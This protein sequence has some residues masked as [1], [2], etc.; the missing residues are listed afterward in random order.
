MKRYLF[1]LIPILLIPLNV[2]ANGTYSENI[3]L[4]IDLKKANLFDRTIDILKELLLN[5]SDLSSE[6]KLKAKTLLAEAQ[7]Q[8]GDYESVLKTT[9]SQEDMENFVFLRAVAFNQLEHYEKTIEIF[10]TYPKAI[11]HDEMIYEV[12]F[13]Y[14]QLGKFEEA[15]LHFERLSLSSSKDLKILSKIYLVKIAMKQGHFD[16]AKR[17]LVQLVKS[18]PKD[19]PMNQNIEDLQESFFKEIC[20]EKSSYF[21]IK[22]E[23]KK[24]ASHKT[25]E[26]YLKAYSLLDSLEIKQNESDSMDGIY[27]LKALY[28]V[29][30]LSLDPSL[31]KKSLVEE[32][33]KKALN[34]PNQAVYG[35]LI[36][37]L[38]G[39]H[40]YQSG[41]YQEAVSIFLKIAK[42]YPQSDF[43][44]DAL[45]KT[46][47]C[48]ENIEESDRS[49]KE[50]K[51]TIYT[52]YKESNHAAI[53]FFSYYSYQEYLEGDRTAI[54][55]LQNFVEK[56][57][58]SPLL[59]KAYY[60]MGLDY[61]RD[62]KTIDGKWIR[63]KNLI[64]AIEQFQQ[65]ESCFNHFLESSQF[66]ENFDEYLEIRYLSLLERALSNYKIAEESQ[67]S[68][69][70]TYL[71]YAEVLFKKIQGELNQIDHSLLKSISHPSLSRFVEESSYWIGVI[72]VKNKRVEDAKLL[73]L[74]M[75]D[76]Y[77]LGSITRG[78]FLCRVYSELAH[79]LIENSDDIEGALSYFLKAEDAA[80]GR[81]L[82]V[83]QKLDLWIQQSLCYEKLQKFDQ[84]ILILSKVINNEAISGLRLKAMYLRAEM[85]LHQGRDELYRKQ[86]ESL[87]KKGGEWALKAKL[88]LEDKL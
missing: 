44:P 56:F 37:D 60:L 68:K 79:L 1:L 43:A 30:I 20:I 21:S 26:A 63:K 65:V 38:L 16:K 45:F 71:N 10:A 76:E 52:N 70:E 34:C 55:H 6:E 85:Y 25:L 74:N 80:K 86:L 12:A 9:D 83:E 28:L 82:N 39:T 42:E 81:V 62:R 14:F 73:F 18:T 3:K 13:A 49:I 53:C 17:E 59:I 24:I 72:C 57:P 15:M 77:R 4:A 40:Y 88:K 64:L 75:L 78:Y 67:G 41:R 46:L 87:S 66:G 47:I 35:D 7:I 61:K 48:M 50:I 58:N 51:K 54:K 2:I 27:L 11:N 29:N 23:A 33:L 69:R 32:N 22:E 36:L 84:A 8:D 5:P 19:H 31:D